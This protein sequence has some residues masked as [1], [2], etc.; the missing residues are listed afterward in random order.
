MRWLDG[1][2]LIGCHVMAIYDR[3]SAARLVLARGRYLACLDCFS[4]PRAYAN[5]LRPGISVFALIGRA[6][7]QRDLKSSAKAARSEAVAAV[8]ADYIGIFSPVF[9]HGVA[10]PRVAPADTLR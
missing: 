10:P 2:V 6:G 4:R 7:Q 1:A 9:C 8:R 5:V 3:E